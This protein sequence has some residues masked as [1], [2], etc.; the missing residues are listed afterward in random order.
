M[1]LVCDWLNINTMSNQAIRDK[2]S[3]L[4]SCILQWPKLVCVFV[5]L[6]SSYFIN[7]SLQHHTLYLQYF[8]Y[9]TFT[10]N[11]SWSINASIIQHIYLLICNW[12]KPI[13]WQNILYLKTGGCPRIYLKRYFP[14]FKPHIQNG[15]L[16]V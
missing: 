7:S 8:S 4:V 13:T 12:S 10:I 5:S 16:C 3:N 14:I 9:L 1:T 11:Y 6:C 15:K 2:N